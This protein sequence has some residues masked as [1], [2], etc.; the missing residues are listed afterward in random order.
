MMWYNII[1]SFIPMNPN[2]YFMYYS[3]IKGLNPLIFGRK[4]GYAIN[5][6]KLKIIP[7]VEQLVQTQYLVKI[8]TCGL[9]QP[10]LISKGVP[11]Q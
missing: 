8:P 11:I 5:V 2:M 1:P 10:N 9:K 4:E 3:R 6:T 7:H